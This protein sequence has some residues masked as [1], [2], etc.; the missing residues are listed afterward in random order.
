MIRET[1]DL[2]R[3]LHNQARLDGGRGR[4]QFLTDR[5]TRACTAPTLLG[6]MESLA[7]GLDTALDYVRGDVFAAFAKVVSSADAHPMLLW[8]RQY[9]R[10]AAMIVTLKPDDYDDGL[11]AV[12]IEGLRQGGA[13]VAIPQ[14]DFHIPITVTALSPLAHGADAKAGNATLF[15]RQQVLATN[16][17]TLDLPFY[18]GNAIRGQMRDLLADHFGQAL[19]L[20]VK[21]KDTAPYALWF[22][23]ALYAGGVLDATA[24]DMKQITSAMGNAGAVKADAVRTFRT[25]LPAL[26][27]LGCALGNRVLQGR[28]AAGNLRP[29][30]AEWGFAAA[31]AVADLLGW[32]FLTR[33]EDNEDRGEEDKHTG[34]IASTEVLKPGT[35]L[36]GGIDLISHMTDLERSA[37]G[38]ALDLWRRNGRIG[39]QNARGLGQVQIEMENAPDPAPYVAWLDDHRAAI[40]DYLGTIGAVRARD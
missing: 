20:T 30:C 38:L 17:A 33:R 13:G 4:D 40:L 9:P 7:G 15:R 6:A 39:A 35:V 18:S 22:F 28:F 2:I 27:L 8:L 26:S 5:L 36:T 29:N 24:T 3:A 34:M 16:G 32:E 14:G 1:F 11:A 25:Q 23:H 10:M 19:G 31:P 12:D 21:S 37:L